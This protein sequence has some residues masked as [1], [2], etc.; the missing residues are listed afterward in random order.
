MRRQDHG[1]AAAARAAAVDVL[2]ATVIDELTAVGVT[3]A[4]REA[5][6]AEQVAENVAALEAEIS[7]ND[8]IVG[9]GGGFGRTEEAHERVLCGRGH[10]SSSSTQ[11]IDKNLSF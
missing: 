3:V 1:R 11:K 5:V 2:R 9:V 8:A 4:D 6:S 10:L 7:R